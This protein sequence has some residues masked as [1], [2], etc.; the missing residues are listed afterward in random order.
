MTTIRINGTTRD[1]D[2]DPQ[3]SLLWAIRDILG[4]TGT[5]FGCWTSIRDDPDPVA[6]RITALSLSARRTKN[7]G[8]PTQSLSARRA[9]NAT[10]C[11]SMTTLTLF[12]ALS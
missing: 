11:L 6:G 10:A 5:K 12:G 1:V 8:R 9:V 7:I 4:L 3:M 2:A